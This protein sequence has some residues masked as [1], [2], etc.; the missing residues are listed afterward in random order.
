MKFS[1]D[2][3]DMDIQIAPGT[4]HLQD[5]SGKSMFEVNALSDADIPI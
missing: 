3:G 2:S 1:N 4:V 5:N